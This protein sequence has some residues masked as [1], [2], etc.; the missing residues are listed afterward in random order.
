MFC[1]NKKGGSIYPLIV[2][3]EAANKLSM[4]TG[5]CFPIIDR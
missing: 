4:I 1:H 5:N 2:N 3:S